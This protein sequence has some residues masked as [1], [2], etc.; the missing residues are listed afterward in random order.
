MSPLMNERLIELGLLDE[1]DANRQ[2]TGSNLSSE[3]AH[4]VGRLVNLISTTSVE[5]DALNTYE[6][7]SRLENYRLRLEGS[8]DGDPYIAVVTNECLHLCEDYLGRS[9]Q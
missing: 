1:S 8:G 7:R 6:F 4:Y 3:W 5:S 9:R 2:Q